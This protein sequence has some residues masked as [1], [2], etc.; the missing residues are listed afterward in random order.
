[1]LSGFF[2]FFHRERESFKA[3]PASPGTQ[4]TPIPEAQ[5]QAPPP[6]RPSGRSHVARLRLAMAAPVD[7]SSGGWA[8]RALRRALA[9]TSLTTLALLASLTG[10]LLSGPAGALPT[11][12]PGWQRQNPDPPVSRTRSLLLD[13]AS[14]Q[15]RL[16]DGFH[17]DAVA[18]ANLTNAIRETG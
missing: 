8:A 7:G 10:L 11:L 15:L 13:A 9:L 3:G 12:G 2:F 14:G 1:M 16:E 17:P 5:A 18:W 4:T 6:P